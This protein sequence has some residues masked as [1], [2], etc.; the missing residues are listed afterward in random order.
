MSQVRRDSDNRYFAPFEG[1]DTPE[2][3]AELLLRQRAGKSSVRDLALELG[4]GKS[5]AANR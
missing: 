4:I 1:L 5:S 3:R 2:G